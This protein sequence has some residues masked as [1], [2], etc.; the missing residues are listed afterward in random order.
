MKGHF[1][2]YLLTA[3]SS[4]ELQVDMVDG[5]AIR[6]G[7]RRVSFTFRKVELTP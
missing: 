6:R 4:F 1:D 2:L 7:S 5:H 3:L